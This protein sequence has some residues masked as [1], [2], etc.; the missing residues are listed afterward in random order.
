MW[1]S[2][3]APGDTSGWQTPFLWPSPSGER[4]E[5]QT[6]SECGK[7]TLRPVGDDMSGHVRACP[8]ESVEGERRCRLP[9]RTS[10][11][12]RQGPAL[13]TVAQMAELVMG[14]AHAQRRN[15][16]CRFES[17]PSRLMKGKASGCLIQ[18]YRPVRMRMASQPDRCGRVATGDRNRDANPR[19][20]SRRDSGNIPRIR[21]DRR[22]APRS[23]TRGMARR[24]ASLDR[25]LSLPAIQYGRKGKG[26]R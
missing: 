20:G 21:R 19:T 25:E 23:S 5:F 13:A 7:T 14:R 8:G 9:W 10:R 2:L 1:N 26:R 18:R 16:G 4:P 22:M 12:I 17:C 3:W 15:V 6:G 24:S 11:G